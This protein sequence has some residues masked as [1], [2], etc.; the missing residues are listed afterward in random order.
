MNQKSPIP[1]LP[2]NLEGRDRLGVIPQSSSSPYVS[3]RKTRRG[4]DLRQ[5]RSQAGC[6]S[7]IRNTPW[8]LIVEIAY[9]SSARYVPIA[10]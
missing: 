8:Y 2:V 6:A 5:P 7:A 4:I 1:L 10:V 9:S 3:K